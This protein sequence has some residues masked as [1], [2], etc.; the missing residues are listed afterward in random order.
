MNSV[1]TD[2]KIPKTAKGRPREF[3]PNQALE[4]A[5]RTFWQKGYRGTSLDDLTEAMRINRPSMYAAFGDKESL[6]LKSIE[7]YRTIYILPPARKLMEAKNLR[8]GLT[9]YFHDMA[10]V[11]A[12]EKNPPGCLIACLLN[13]ESGESEIIRE[14]LSKSIAAS[15]EKFEQLFRQHK[16]ELA[17]GIEPAAAGKMLITTMHGLSIRARSGASKK[18]LLPIAETFMKLV[19]KQ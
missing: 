13:E 4:K 7:H 18:A 19:L 2:T 10:N 3:D 17:P 8:D 6:F 12:N 1:S 11:I 9:Q 14:V 5:L 16:S 15:D